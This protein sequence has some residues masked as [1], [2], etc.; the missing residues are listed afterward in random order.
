MKNIILFLLLSLSLNLFAQSKL[1]LLI[2][3]DISYLPATKSYIA[4]VE[5]D[6]GTII[7]PTYINDAFKN[8]LDSVKCWV[9]ASFGIKKDAN[10]KVTKLYDLKGLFD[11]FNTDTSKCPT[12]LASGINGKPAISFDGV[13]DYLIDTVFAGITQPT[14]HIIALQRNSTQFAV[15]IS[16]NIVSRQVIGYQ[17]SGSPPALYIYAGASLNDTTILGVGTKIILSAVFNGVNS[18][19]YINNV[20]K[21]S[22]NAGTNIFG[23]NNVSERT[24]LGTSNPSA[25]FSKT[26]LGDYILKQNTGL[27]LQTFLNTK[28]AIY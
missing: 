16:D 25:Q 8:N 20:L 9:S 5:A 13:N 28:Y 19:I 21:M 22:G 7:N 11:Y 4:R 10:N 23:S 24:L 17:G 2:G 12:W 15:Q 27:S 26:I 3:D 14:T 18:K 6:G 1:L